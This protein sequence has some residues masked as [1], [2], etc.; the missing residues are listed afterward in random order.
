MRLHISSPRAIPAIGPLLVTRGHQH[1]PHG[2]VTAAPG[3]ASG[4]SHSSERG[5]SQGD[6]GSG[7]QAVCEIPS[8]LDMLSP[9]YIYT[10]P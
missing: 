4:Q 2:Q 10:S 3:P 5:E 8:L 9:R 6:A 7:D 1:W